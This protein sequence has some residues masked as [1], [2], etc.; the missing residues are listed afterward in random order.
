MG[1]KSALLVDLV[2]IILGIVQGEHRIGLLIGVMEIS[3]VML[4]MQLETSH[5]HPRVRIVVISGVTKEVKVVV[6]ST[7][8]DGKIA[9]T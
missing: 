7:I 2:I 5:N 3:E 8:I 6:K 1:F 4:H 9:L